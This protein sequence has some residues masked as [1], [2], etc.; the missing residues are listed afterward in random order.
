MFH[1]T[2]GFW[3]RGVRDSPH[4][5]QL[6]EEA[7]QPSSPNTRGGSSLVGFP[8]PSSE[9]DPGIVGQRRQYSSCVG[10]TRPASTCNV[11]CRSQPAD[12]VQVTRGRA[13]NPCQLVTIICENHT[14]IA[15]QQ[16]SGTR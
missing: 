13:L 9:T 1:L 4:V 12:R 16:D 8:S 7:G 5:G 6:C 11:C 10:E 14:Q 15:D 2:Q 3:T